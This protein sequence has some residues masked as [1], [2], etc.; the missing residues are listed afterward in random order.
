VVGRFVRVVKQHVLHV[1]ERLLDHGLVRA[2]HRLPD[3]ADEVL[4][5]LL[6]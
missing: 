4:V 6:L 5:A 3:P 2:V 1:V